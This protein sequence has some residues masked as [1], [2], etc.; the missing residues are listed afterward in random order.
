[1]PSTQGFVLL[2]VGA[3]P[4]LLGS[5]NQDKV[6]ELTETGVTGGKHYLQKVRGKGLS[7][8]TLCSLFLATI[9][10]THRPLF[11]QWN[12]WPMELW[13]HKIAGW[14]AVARPV[15]LCRTFR[16]LSGS[17]EPLPAPPFWIGLLDPPTPSTCTRTAFSLDLSPTLEGITG[18]NSPTPKSEI[19]VSKY[20]R[21]TCTYFLAPKDQSPDE[22]ILGK[23]IKLLA[24]REFSQLSPNKQACK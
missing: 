11:T 18:S 9:L 17:P 10:E 15:C 6:A 13:P 24:A 21:V 4:R 7:P 22:G 8:L 1:M 14:R 5:D 3:K 20:Y 19:V 16:L 23:C 12:S 2:L